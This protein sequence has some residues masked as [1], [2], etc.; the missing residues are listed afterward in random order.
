MRAGQAR[1][2]SSE[3][4][5][6]ALLV[7]R[8]NDLSGPPPFSVTGRLSGS[9][10]IANDAGGNIHIRPTG[11]GSTTGEVR[12]MQSGA[13][14]ANY[15]GTAGEPTYSWSGDPDTGI[16]RTG[17]NQLALATGGTTRLQATNSGVSVTTLS[18]ILSRPDE[19]RLVRGDTTGLLL[20]SGGSSWNNG[21]VVRLYGANHSSTPS[22]GELRSGADLIAYWRDDAFVVPTTLVIPVK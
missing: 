16:H 21:G 5:V 18:L 13:V 15:Y 8:P 12:F 22:R 1:L 9:S 19:A 4:L 2:H 7:S 17:E 14:Q 3:D 10:V 20:M 11:Q 6:P